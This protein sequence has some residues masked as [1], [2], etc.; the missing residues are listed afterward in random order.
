MAKKSD[1]LTS[2]EFSAKTGISKSRV[3]KL[4]RDGKIKAEKKSGKWMIGPD[5]LNAKAVKKA[6]KPGK[7]SPKK[8]TTPTKP[9]KTPMAAKKTPPVS[10][11]AS[12][13]EAP[14]HSSPTDR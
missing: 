2:S 1:L 11:I 10:A 8:K 12:P 9:K 7:P 5:Q 3:S 4:I 13:I 6:Q 14:A